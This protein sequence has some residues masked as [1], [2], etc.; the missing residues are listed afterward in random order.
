MF[1][2]RNNKPSTR[3]GTRPSYQLGN[4]KNLKGNLYVLSIF[5]DDK[6]SRWTDAS[7]ISFWNKEVKPGF[8][9]LSKEASKYGVRLSFEHGSFYTGSM[10]NV[11]MY[12]DGVVIPDTTKYW[13]PCINYLMSVTK[14]LGFPTI[15]AFHENMQHISKGKEIIY[16]IF[17]NKQ[18]R[19]YAVP[20]QTDDANDALE[21][22]ILFRD[23]IGYPTINNASSI[24][25][26]ILHLFGA[27]DY[28][29]PFGNMPKRA[30]LAEKLCP[31]DIMLKP[32]TD[33]SYNK[34][35]KFTAYTIGWLN[36][37]PKEYDLD[38]WWR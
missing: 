13:D 14:A 26:E 25:H 34:I 36:Q 3:T 1:F 9:F 15:S 2:R 19:S 10:K 7:R 20:D 6:E 33:V 38:D 29:N 24:A 18:G 12:Y 28:Y 27:E 5:L 11:R 22:T 21:Y 35:G 31:H 17:L 30:A 16:L 37:L 32:Y 23:L 8:Q 4:C